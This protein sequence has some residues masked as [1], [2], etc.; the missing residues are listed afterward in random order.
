MNLADSVHPRERPQSYECRKEA[1]WP[2][3]KKQDKTASIPKELKTP[4]NEHR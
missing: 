4:Q 2:A 3:K 1:C